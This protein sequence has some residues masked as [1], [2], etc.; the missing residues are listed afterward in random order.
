MH[1][2]VGSAIQRMT[3]RRQN[4]MVQIILLKQKEN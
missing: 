1:E 3:P 2:N 4:I